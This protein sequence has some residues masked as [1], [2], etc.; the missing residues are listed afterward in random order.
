[1]RRG[2]GPF[3]KFG[4]VR[5]SS[6]SRPIPLKLMIPI[7]VGLVFLLLALTAAKVGKDRIKE[8]KLNG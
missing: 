3:E 4:C 2:V 8:T 7:P 6:D 5:A 1:M